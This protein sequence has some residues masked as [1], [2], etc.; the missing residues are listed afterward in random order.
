MFI[1]SEPTKPVTITA[2][3]IVGED[4]REEEQPHSPTSVA[5]PGEDAFQDDESVLLEADGKW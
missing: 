2:P 1:S 3:S 4:N 5:N